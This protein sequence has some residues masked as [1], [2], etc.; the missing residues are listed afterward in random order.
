M[1]WNEVVVLSPVR[2]TDRETVVQVPELFRTIPACPAHNYHTMQPIAL[3]AWQTGSPGRTPA[4]SALLA[5]SQAVQEVLAIP[6]SD[7]RLVYHSSRAKGYY[8]TIQ[9][10]LTPAVLPPSLTRVHLSISIEGVQ[11]ERLFEA[12][13][14]LRH[15]Y[16]WDRLNIYRQRV[17]GVT[18][19]TIKV[20]FLN[21]IQR[22]RSMNQLG[23]PVTAVLLW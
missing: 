3:A 23:G 7:I 8:S 17:Y 4:Q 14:N 6:G 13:P 10:Q 1:P 16:A 2:L 5:E 11:E 12:D 22:N 19:A 18:T 20:E 15:T 21:S 9:L